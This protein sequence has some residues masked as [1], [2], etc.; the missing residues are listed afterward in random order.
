MV[1]NRNKPDQF[2]EPAMSSMPTGGG[3]DLHFRS[4][5]MRLNKEL[6]EDELTEEKL[7][8]SLLWPFVTKTLKLTFIDEKDAVI[9]KQLLESEVCKIM[10]STPAAMQDHEFFKEIGAARIIALMNINRAR[11]TENAN[12]KLN[13]RI[14]NISQFSQHFTGTVGGTSREGWLS[15]IFGGRR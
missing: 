1:L 9:L 15:K 11:G 4:E 10:R 14:A 8:D 5:L 13:E 7:K 3:D 6:I 12:S 2:I